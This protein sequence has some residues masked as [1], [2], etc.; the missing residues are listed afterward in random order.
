MCIILLVLV[1]IRN[2]LENWIRQKGK[3][4]KN[5]SK[6]KERRK[7]IKKIKN[8]NICYRLDWTNSASCCGA[9]K[10]IFLQWLST[11][12]SYFLIFN[13]TSVIS[14]VS[15]KV[16]HVVQHWFR[17]S[18]HLIYIYIS[19]YFRSEHQSGLWTK[20]LLI[21]IYH[22]ASI[23]R[24]SIFSVNIWNIVFVAWICCPTII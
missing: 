19:I 12:I 13:F 1:G 14:L 2:I 3:T 9:H 4:N 11:E 24:N 10:K 6:I 7:K 5:E 22:Q 23:F 21:C 20:H 17:F 18:F 15:I 16:F 8:K